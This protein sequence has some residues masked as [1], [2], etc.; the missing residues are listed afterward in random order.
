MKKLILIT[1]L[2]ILSLTLRSQTLLRRGVIIGNGGN[3]FTVD[4]IIKSTTFFKLYNGATELLAID[5]ATMLTK[6]IQ[7]SDTSL[8]LSKYIHRVDT[9]SML[10][11]Y[12]HRTDTAGMLTKYARKASPTF[13]GTVTLPTAT[14]IGDVSSTEIGYVNGV[15]GAI[16]TQLDARKY[17]PY[18]FLIEE[19][20]G[21]TYARPNPNTAY[22]ATSNAV[23]STV[24]QAVVNQLTSGGI[25]KIGAGN[26]DNSDSVHVKYSDITFI[27]AGKEK[28]K[29]KLKDDFDNGL[30]FN[31]SYGFFHVTGERVS[32]VD[33]EIDANALGQDSIDHGHT[34]DHYGSAKVCAILS[35]DA[36]YMTIDNC[37]IHDATVTAIFATGCDYGRIL[38]SHIEDGYWNNITLG[39]G[40]QEW[41]IDNCII[42]GSTPTAADSSSCGDVGIALY[43]RYH[44][45]TNNLIKN[46]VGTRGHDNSQAGISLEFA[47]DNNNLNEAARPSGMFIFD[48]R[49]EGSGMTSGIVNNGRGSGSKGAKID[50]NY[51]DSCKYAISWW[52]DSATITNNKI[53]A[54]QIGSYTY[55]IYIQAGD[56]NLIS[57]NDV[58]VPTT[59][60][61][62]YPLLITEDAD[63]TPD[64]GANYNKAVG[65]TLI[66]GTYYSIG[67][68]GNDCTGNYIAGNIFDDD[69][70]DATDIYDTGTGTIKTYDN[71]DYNSS[72]FNPITTGSGRAVVYTGDAASVAFGAADL[73]TTGATTTGSL[74]T[75]VLQ[76]GDATSNT[77]LSVDSIS[78]DGTT[79]LVFD[80]ATQLSPNIS[81]SGQGELSAYVPLLV[82][83]IPLFVFGLGGGLTADTAVFNDNA[84]AGAFY[85]EGSDTLVVTQLMGILAE[86]TGTE[87]VSI[88]VSWHATF[89]SG[90]ATN[91]NAAALA[92]TSITTGTTDVSFPNYKIPP[93]V[94]V[95]C[96]ISG[97]SPGNRP[98]FL[99]VTISGYKIP[100]Y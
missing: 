67:V 10:T 87:T 18:D 52:G 74:A 38:N 34:P 80:G 53:Y 28:T 3:T 40:T 62:N 50:N 94:F 63:A 99:S 8:M 1:A 81:A 95:W 70:N 39:W 20:A 68:S 97:V 7:R 71:Y 92:I 19:V 22:T 41:V 14:S 77:I 56:Y 60:S 12:I 32:F 86:G 91:L 24:L 33:L 58:E 13:T 36:H 54:Y 61:G 100:T 88:Q 89:K 11:P 48:N 66:G 98:S 16:Q 65:N 31:T 76:V 51:F 44:R 45:V 84:L 25:V 17:M 37:Y 96:T 26:F 78:T 72:R 85:N 64:D 4:S 29:F 46:I 15:T 6:Y 57:G 73:T 30:G 90:S 9:S 93:N 21:T 27:G 42:D 83:T 82:D 35:E 2:I 49:F 69:T 55:G 5:T 23:P 79:Y 43:G 75:E 47:S 59:G